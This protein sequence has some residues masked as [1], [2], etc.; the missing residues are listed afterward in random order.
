MNN[1]S[2]FLAHKNNKL[3]LAFN[4]CIYIY[5]VSFE[6]AFNSATINLNLNNLR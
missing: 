3:I 4:I 2:S 5:I 1:F 6:I